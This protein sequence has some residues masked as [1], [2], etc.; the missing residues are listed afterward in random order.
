MV[1]FKP[2]SV[3]QL[4]VV[5]FLF[6]LA[7][8]IF[9]VLRIS[10]SLDELA[11]R[12]HDNLSRAVMVTRASQE[13]VNLTTDVE[14]AVKQIQLIGKSELVSVVDTHLTGLEKIAVQLRSG[15]SHDLVSSK[16]EPFQNKIA[17][18]K[19][20]VQSMYESPTLTD[21]DINLALGLQRDAESL[22]DSTYLLTDGIIADTERLTTEFKQDIVVMSFLVVSITTLLVMG[23]SFL[24]TRPIWQLHGAIEV[25][26]S[27]RFAKKFKVTGPKELESL[28]S[29][30][31]WL[32]SK[33]K[34][35]DED[36]QRFLEHISHE[37]KTPLAGMKEGGALLADEVP[38]PLTESQ[39]EVVEIIN[40]NINVFQH[41]IESLLNYNLLRSHRAISK[42]SVHVD[43][44]VKDVL[45]AHK[46]TIAR[47]QLEVSTDGPDL[48]TSLDKRIMKVALDNLI[49]N[50][51]SFSPDK[52]KVG[53]SWFKDAKGFYIEVKDQGPGISK[54][55]SQ[56]IFDPFYQGEARRRGPIKG[57]GLGLSLAQE[58]VEAHNGEI[59]VIH[60]STDK[61][62]S[63]AYFQIK[64]PMQGDA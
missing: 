62:F 10:L 6:V 53:V 47:K 2:K 12:N 59:E 46:L 9:A 44:M 60:N 8:V 43:T 5:G 17:A 27:G 52:S 54:S 33:L 41:C 35:V 4:V 42:E 64:L 50:A 13:A 34:E 30:L 20:K 18:I 32:G 29:K 31:N 21:A 37:L 14:R 15:L 55:E 26:G 24:I 56:A 51:L 63:G 19:E 11:H 22:R 16:M 1:I 36:K 28:G 45:N 3:L 40:S 48:E 61:T 57:S 58:C 38:G 7:P 23:F 25:L 39:R 49:S